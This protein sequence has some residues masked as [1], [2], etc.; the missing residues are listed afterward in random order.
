MPQ[1]RAALVGEEV[2]GHGPAAALVT[3]G[4]GERDEDVVEE[5]LGE[6]GT[7]VHGADRPHR[8]PG[9][10][11]VHEQG[12]DPPVGRL[13]GSCPGQQHTAVGVLGQARPDLLSVDAPAVVGAVG[14]A[15]QG[16]QVAAGVGL[17]EALAP[18]LVPPQQ[19]RDHGGRQVRV[20]VVD[21]RRGEDLGHRV[22][23]GLDQVPGGERFTEVRPG[24]GG[25]AQATHPLGPAGTHPSG[26]VGQA[27]H[28]GQLV[29]LLVERSGALEAGGQ[30]R[31]LRLEPV[32]EVPAESG[33]VPGASGVHG[34][35]GCG[36]VGS[37]ARPESRAPLLRRKVMDRVWRRHPS[38]VRR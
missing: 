9:G 12:G 17:G 10:V 18:R 26:V 15:G 29:H 8:D 21:H 1:R 23:P 22:E 11:H 7:A 38:A 13:D 35:D 31:G 2:H 24:Q 32:V 27:L 5:Q 6:L 36:R 30:R 16:G 28:L 14:P 25:A 19:G 3:Q 34:V 20:G 33:Q 4:P 37:W